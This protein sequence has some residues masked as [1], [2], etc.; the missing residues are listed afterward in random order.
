MFRRVAVVSLCLIPTW[1]QAADWINLY[2]NN[3]RTDGYVGFS[4]SKNDQFDN[5]LNNSSSKG[6]WLGEIFNENVWSG[7]IDKPWIATTIV[8]SQLKANTSSYDVNSNETIS[9]ISAFAGQQIKLYPDSDYPTIFRLGQTLGSHSGRRGY[10]YAH[11]D[12]HVTNTYTPTGASFSTRINY[13][14]LF[15]REFASSTESDDGKRLDHE[16]DFEFNDS[17][18]RG[19][20]KLIARADKLDIEYESDNLLSQ[21]LR[22]NL[23]LQYLQDWQF[24]EQDSVYLNASVSTDK[25]AIDSVNVLNNQSI[26]IGSGYD[27]FQ[28][29]VSSFIRSKEIEN[30][31]YNL[32]AYINQTQLESGFSNSAN[33]AKNAS[34]YFATIYDYDQNWQFD[35]SIDSYY[36][37]SNGNGS[38]F[39]AAFANASYQQSAELSESIRYQFMVNNGIGLDRGDRNGENYA[40]RMGNGFTKFI[41]VYDTSLQI[42]FD[43]LVS[44]QVNNAKNVDPEQW[45]ISHDLDF[46]WSAYQGGVSSTALLTLSDTRH[47]TDDLDRFQQIYLT[48]RRSTQLGDYDSWGGDFV[49]EWNSTVFDDGS[50]GTYNR[51]WGNL[52]YRNTE[53]WD[54]QNL[55][56]TSE[57]RVPLNDLLPDEN[58]FGNSR[59]VANWHNKLD[60]R[61][62]L[63]ELDFNATMTEDYYHLALNIKRNFNF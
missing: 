53:L 22:Q 55:R 45:Q 19:D 13:R 5:D 28:T 27:V 9:T 34:V 61:I 56:F 26:K 12:F 36:S 43:Q 7:Y 54:I 23:S 47:L 50:S 39:Y 21:D 49:Y 18:S 14:A 63:L 31:T 8:T 11:T 42:S 16:L 48:L 4:F 44:H 3:Q 37:E 59:Q 2:D 32:N 30:L 20:Y 38:Q 10:E 41:S 57:L 17:H 33:T 1:V 15:D 40:F 29:N 25:Y 58:R 24:N 6:S 35:G 60:Y 46:E 52:F 62:G 51:A